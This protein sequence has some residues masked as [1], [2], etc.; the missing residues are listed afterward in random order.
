MWDQKET[1]EI[2]KQVSAGLSPPEFTDWG[3][4]LVNPFWVDLPHC[5]IFQCFTPD[6]LHQLHKGVFKDHI[7]KWATMAVNIDG[8]EHHI[9]NLQKA[10][11]DRHF[12]TMS[13]HPSL[14]HFKKGNEYKNM[15]KVFLSVIT[16][17]ADEKV[18]KCVR[19]VIDF[20][21][22]AHYEEQTTQSL[23]KLE[24]SWHTFHKCK[25]IF[26]DQGIHNHFNIPK[27]HSMS[28][29]ASMIRLHGSTGGYNTEASEWLHINYAKIVYNASNKK[30]HDGDNDI[31]PSTDSVVLPSQLEY[32]ESSYYIPKTTSYSNVSINKLQAK[33]GASK[34]IYAMEAFLHKHCLLKADY[35]DAIPATYSV[36][37]QFCILIPPTPEVSP[38]S[39]MDS[40]RATLL[41]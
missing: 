40:I 18:V 9:D 25:A 19:A 22:Y 15:E 37:K 35:W 1:V 5:N 27:I 29:Y 20:I 13:Q 17:L 11:V 30:G 16:G 28:H 31:T 8:P 38:L 4:R 36:Y 23:E 7:I 33:F 32:G 3:L 14:W 39:T 6:I 26:L 24:E 21:Y 34:F 12:Q 2:L 10:E 41:E